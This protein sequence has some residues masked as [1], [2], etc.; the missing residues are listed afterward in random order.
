MNLPLYVVNAFT[1]N[2][3]GGNPAAVCP[4]TEWLPDET[5][6]N[7]ASQHNLSETAFFVPSTKTDIDYHIR[8]FTPTTEVDLCGHATLATAYVIYN[9]LTNSQLTANQSTQALTFECQVGKLTISKD[10]DGK[11]HMDFPATVIQPL[12]TTATYGSICR[13]RPVACYTGKNHDLVLVFEHEAQVRDAM[14]H[15]QAIK[16]LVNN[17]CVIATAKGDESV[18]FVCRVFA[19]NVGIDEDPVTGS[20][21]TLLAPLWANELDKTSFVAK[22]LSARGGDVWC[23]YKQDTDMV[24]VAGFAVLYAKGAIFID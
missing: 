13:T 21:F 10:T 18:D 20:A 1:N 16:S 19:P 7:I 2:T 24:N 5:L 15:F 17:R 9:Q 6:Q 23:D 8:W 12:N 14:P 22:Q 3:F 11:I 4:L